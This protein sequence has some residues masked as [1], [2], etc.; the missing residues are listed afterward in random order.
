MKT[1]FAFVIFLVCLL[2]LGYEC[3]AGF[4]PTNDAGIE[5]VKSDK[6]DT[7][8]QNDMEHNPG[9]SLRQWFLH[10]AGVSSGKKHEKTDDENKEID[11]AFRTLNKTVMTNALKD[12]DSKRSVDETADEKPPSNNQQD[13]VD[14]ALKSVLTSIITGA[15]GK[16]SVQYWDKLRSLS[17]ADKKTAQL[18][19]KPEEIADLTDTAK[20]AIER[21]NGLNG[22]LWADTATD[23]IIRSQ[24]ND[25]GLLEN[26][27]RAGLQ[28]ATSSA[29]QQTVSNV[30]G[31]GKRA[32][33]VGPGD[34]MNTGWGRSAADQIADTSTS[35]S[36]GDGRTKQNVAYSEK[37]NLRK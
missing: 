21:Y 6:H 23:K 31:Q 10:D 37:S 25:P 1:S 28:A 26:A 27:V 17:D 11:T 9:P 5:G 13:L 7:A 33:G 8:T 4:I 20:E 22:P 32:V 35:V 24:S 16:R 2:A 14:S 34:D 19:N 30:M 3:R 15:L 29:A 12:L 18:W 36:G